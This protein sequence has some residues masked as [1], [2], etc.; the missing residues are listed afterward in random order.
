MISKG[1]RGHQWGTTKPSQAKNSFQRALAVKPEVEICGN[2]YNRL[3]DLDF[4]F[5]LLYIIGSISNRLGSARGRWSAIHQRKTNVYGFFGKSYGY[6]QK[7]PRYRGS[8]LVPRTKMAYSMINFLSPA[9][10]HNKY[11]KN[12]VTTKYAQTCWNGLKCRKTC[13]YETLISIGREIFTSPK[14]LQYRT[15]DQVW[16]FVLG[17]FYLLHPQFL[18]IS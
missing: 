10:C 7:R 1:L 16:P 13:Y 17:A 8:N 15:M 4:L 14:L 11:E 2:M 5:N 12:F 9:K 3:P 18:A 6:L